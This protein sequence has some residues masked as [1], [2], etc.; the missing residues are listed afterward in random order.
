ML[1]SPY[2]VRIVIFCTNNAAPK[3]IILSCIIF[4]YKNLKSCYIQFFK[5]CF[6][7]VFCLFYFFL[8]N[9]TL[10]VM[11]YTFY[12]DIFQYKYMQ[13][14]F[15]VVKQ[16]HARVTSKYFC[17]L[18]IIIIF[19]PISVLVYLPIYLAWMNFPLGLFGKIYNLSKMCNLDKYFSF[20]KSNLSGNSFTYLR[21]FVTFLFF[22]FIKK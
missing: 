7:F 8:F 4:L 13:I 18:F 3:S 15:H 14:A 12:W 9:N 19:L 10:H 16:Y 11:F 1:R 2:L 21:H 17:L 22:V 5:R 6:F 20:A